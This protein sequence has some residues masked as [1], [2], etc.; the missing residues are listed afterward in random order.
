LESLNIFYANLGLRLSPTE[1]SLIEGAFRDG[2]LDAEALAEAFGAIAITKAKGLLSDSIKLAKE[3]TTAAAKATKAGFESF[4]KAGST[5]DLSTITEDS[6]E[7]PILKSAIEIEL[8]K[9]LAKSFP[10]FVQQRANVAN[11]PTGNWHLTVGNPMN[12]IMRIGDV[13]VRDCTMTFGEEL[14]PDD[15]P[16]EMKFVVNVSPVKP[17]NS[18]DIRRT[19]NTGRADYALPYNGHTF[20]QSNTYGVI[21]KRFLEQSSGRGGAGNQPPNSNTQLSGGMKASAKTWLTDRYGA[22]MVNAKFFEDVYFYQANKK[23]ETQGG[24]K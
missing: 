15:F 17:R 3:A 13:V 14:G 16:I 21:N 23:D 22:K 1:E 11:I 20:D 24:D 9:A 19:F 4:F 12:P 7:F 2:V 8:T 10:G 18:T 6:K 5:L